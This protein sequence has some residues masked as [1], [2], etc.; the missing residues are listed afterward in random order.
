MTIQTKSPS[1]STPTNPSIIWHFNKQ[2]KIHTDSS[3][4]ATKHAGLKKHRSRGISSLQLW[5]FEQH[6]SQDLTYI[7]HYIVIRRFWNN[8]ETQ[9][10]IVALIRL[11][12]SRYPN[13]SF[14]LS[15]S[16]LKPYK[17]S[18]ELLLWALR[19]KKNS[20][21]LLQQ[22]SLP[23]LT[24]KKTPQLS[25]DSKELEVGMAKIWQDVW[26]VFP[27]NWYLGLESELRFVMLSSRCAFFPGDFKSGMGV[28]TSSEAGPK[29]MAA[30]LWLNNTSESYSDLFQELF[31]KTSNST[32]FWG[33]KNCKK[34]YSSGLPLQ[35]HT[36]A[37][38]LG[39]R[40]FVLESWI[41][42]IL[43]NLRSQIL[44]KVITSSRNM[45]FIVIVLLIPKNPNPSQE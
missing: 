3:A 16:K 29:K 24:N 28:R 22:D 5:K 40:F 7:R 20:L 30:I 45:L 44:C 26:N 32:A 31:G 42:T 14:E 2:Q 17:A 35:C 1:W 39:R 33:V 15:S 36:K 18:L 41:A 19:I 37:S 21:K 8:S 27:L 11:K 10:F 4:S 13:I 12:R 38:A 9:L 6:I 34:S 43:T 25:K 23:K